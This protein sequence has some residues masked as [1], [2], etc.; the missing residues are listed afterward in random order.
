MSKSIRISDE[1]YKKLTS[2][3]EG[4]IDDKFSTLLEKNQ[5]TLIDQS[6]PSATASTEPP[7]DYILGSIIRYF[8]ITAR[9]I[10]NAELQLEDMVKN[11][12]TEEDEKEIA[13]F[14]KALDDLKKNEN[15]AG[16][17]NQI[18]QASKENGWHLEYP[19]FFE[20][21]TKKDSRYLKKLDK[22]LEL[23]VRHEVLERTA[24]GY[25]LIVIPIDQNE[26]A[27]LTALRYQTVTNAPPTIYYKQNQKRKTFSNGQEVPSI[28]IYK[29]KK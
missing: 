2:I 28:D 20:S 15:R 12:K 22:C 10:H 4:K 21:H 11:Q 7:T 16:C 19:T 14:I 23:L 5:Q 26:V 3:G 27:K 9:Q 6:K 13:K 1:N 17:K 25:K 18:W 24:T 8:Y 29:L